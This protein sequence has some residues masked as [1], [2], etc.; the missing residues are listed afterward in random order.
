MTESEKS[1]KTLTT[2]LTYGELVKYII[3]LNNKKNSGINF[4]KW[5]SIRVLMYTYLVKLMLLSFSILLY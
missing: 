5:V 4:A 2:Q 3:S 1:K